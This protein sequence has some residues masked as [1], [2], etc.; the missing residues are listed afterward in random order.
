MRTMT[1]PAVKPRT[2]GQLR[3]RPIAEEALPTIRHYLNMAHSRTCDYSIGG[4]YM[5]IDYFNYRYCVWRDT[6]FIQGVDEDD[7]S[8]TAY[9]LPIGSLPLNE[10]INALRRH[11]AA[12]GQQLRFSAIP[13]DALPM[14]TQ[15]NPKG[16]EQLKNWSDYIYDA[17]SLATMAGNK[18]KKKRNHVNRFMADNP[19]TALEPFDKV[20]IE[21]SKRL[22][23]RLAET[24]KE[25]SLLASVER[26]QVYQILDNWNLFAPYFEGAVLRDASNAVIAFTV[27]EVIGDTLFVHIEKMDHEVPGAG[28]TI[29]KL[30]AEMMTARHPEVKYINREEDV[31]DEGLR[32]AKE[33]YHP[34][35]LLT[36][37]NV[38]F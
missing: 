34:L 17:Q 3:F 7:M 2:I 32:A 31:G 35:Q 14:F 11:C 10:A 6:L 13:E 9:S 8:K 23:T 20:N 15:A 26:T 4:I 24:S 22:L 21:E 19:G 33:S 1:Y 38:I 37:Y 16:I 36:K 30:F 25:P 27:G 12:T 28:E 5:W 29:N 18:L